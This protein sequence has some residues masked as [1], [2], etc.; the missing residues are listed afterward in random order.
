MDQNIAGPNV[1][2]TNIAEKLSD[3]SLYVLE[4]IRSTNND[5]KLIMK[6]FSVKAIDLIKF[7]LNEKFTVKIY[8]FKIRVNDDTHEKSNNLL[9]FQGTN[10]TNAVG[11]LEEG[12]KSSISGLHGSGVYL[13]ASSHLAMECSIKKSPKANS[14][15]E[16]VVL[17]N[18]VIYSE[19]LKEIGTEIVMI[20]P[21]IFYT[22]LLLIVIWIFGLFCISELLKT[23]GILLM[24]ALFACFIYKLLMLTKKN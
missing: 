7:K 15:K 17:V 4:D 21:T 14:I 2:F 6:I 13:T 24:L 19:K 12:F 8:S 22:F 11:I 20:I 9:L 3:S 1:N 5:Y 16:I 18:E 10:I 23:F